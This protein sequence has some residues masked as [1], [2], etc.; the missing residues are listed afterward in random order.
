MGSKSSSD[1]LYHNKLSARLLSL[2][3]AITFAGL[4]LVSSN[5]I[6]DISSYTDLYLALT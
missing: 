5:H 1:D 2:I 3:R 6:G 4:L